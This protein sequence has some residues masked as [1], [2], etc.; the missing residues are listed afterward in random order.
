MSTRTGL[1]F[2]A[3]LLFLG[4][5]SGGYAVAKI[6]IVYAEP[7]TI[8][9]IR[10]ALV[11]LGMGMLFAILRPPLPSTGRDWLH[12]SVVGLLLQAVYFGFSYLAFAEGVAAGT[13]ALIM[14]LQP[15]LVALIA[16]R[17]TTERVSAVAWTGLA[18]G[19]SGAVIVILARLEVAAPSLAGLFFAL[20]G[21]TGMIGATLYE[22][23]FGLS[24]HPV[25]ANLIGFAVGF[26]GILPIALLTE[27]QQI[28]L[29]WEFAGAMA[30]LVIGN[31]IIATS[32]L[33][34]MIRAGEVA[35]VS[36]L[37]FLVPPMASL[38]A[39]GLLGEVMP[40]AA[41]L[42]MGLAGAGVWLATRAR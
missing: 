3:P 11:V 26:A 41:W 6:A 12:L 20:I 40:L 17:F 16:P 36:A 21:L 7:M 10:Y 15:I 31:S 24:H 25:T 2:A 37:L 42:G 18:M 19:L 29:T 34:A 8:L 32:L 23:R 14:S 22:K 28:N 13:V 27:S 9:A 5:W 1:L 33:L 39:W 35:R 38:I 4:L 30:Y